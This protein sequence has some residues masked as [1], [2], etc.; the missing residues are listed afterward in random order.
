MGMATMATWLKGPMGFDWEHLTDEKCDQ[1]SD[2]LVFA[3]A[4]QWHKLHS[5]PEQMPKDIREALGV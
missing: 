1:K 2:E 3:H 4:V 5:T